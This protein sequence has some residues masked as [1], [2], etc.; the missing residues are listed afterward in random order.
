MQELKRHVGLLLA[1]VK[2][3]VEGVARSFMKISD[4]GWVFSNCS[5][6]FRQEA[7]GV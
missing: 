7:D 6:A 3:P 4:F 1:L 2:A 5:A